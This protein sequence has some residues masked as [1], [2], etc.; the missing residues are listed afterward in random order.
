MV[1]CEMHYFAGDTL[2]TKLKRTIKVEENSNV[3]LEEI[4]SAI[5]GM[6]ILTNLCENCLLHYLQENT[7]VP[8]AYNFNLLNIFHFFAT[9]LLIFTTSIVSTLID[10]EKIIAK[11]QDD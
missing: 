1:I 4:L 8:C 9:C 6:D 7:E 2:V 5:P 3:A 11:F 10:V